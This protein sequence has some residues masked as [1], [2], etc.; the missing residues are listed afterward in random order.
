MPRARRTLD[1]FLSLGASAGL[2][3]TPI[4]ELQ[5]QA[6]AMPHSSPMHHLAGQG[7]EG[8]EGGEGGPAAAVAVS[9]ADI[10]LVLAQMQGH[11]L[12]AQEL[13]EQRNH[14]AAEPHVGHPVDELYGTL[15]PALQQG[16]IQP[17]LSSLEALRQQVRLN[18]QD[19]ATNG[20]L[21]QAQQAIAAAA[22][23]LPGARAHD[24]L[25]V[26]TVVPQLAQTAVLEYEGALA[27]D[28][29]VEVIEY[30]DARG[31]LR[32]ALSMVRQA[33]AHQPSAAIQLRPMET[34]LLAMLKAFPTA[35]PPG[36]AVMGLANMQQLQKQL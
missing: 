11:L 24:P 1:I 4:A 8:G 12:M 29:V 32:Q 6:Q 34:T 26:K 3:T 20:K 23:S 22:Q 15:K 5:A 36:K 9:D 31:F 35:Q 18:P 17:F 10:L 28:Q 14:Q 2:L 21:N 7:G 19:P 27:G 33:M 13:L 25:L 16:K 30:Q